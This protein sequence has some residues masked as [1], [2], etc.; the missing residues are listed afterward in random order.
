[1]E[2]LFTGVQHE[3]RRKPQNP[4]DFRYEKNVH[5][6][7]T[8]GKSLKVDG[9]PCIESFLKAVP[10]F[11]NK[12]YGWF[13]HPEID[14][15]NGYASYAEEGDGKFEMNAACWKRN[16]SKL[17]VIFS[18]DLAY[19]NT[20]KANTEDFCLAGDSKFYY[21]SANIIGNPKEHRFVDNDTGFAVYLYAPDT[22]TLEKMIEPP[23]NGWDIRTTNS[24]LVLP[25]NGKDI[26]VRDGVEFDD[27][28][29]YSYHSLKW[30]GMTFDYKY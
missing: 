29:H 4:K 15:A 20:H 11:Y 1:M 16:D 26:K 27:A 22:K 21:I 25:Q 6:H 30:N 28:K 2:A 8:F 23:F 19:F 14:N 9:T 5:I 10:S 18:Y 24:F 17:L 12:E 3:R 13:I 7:D